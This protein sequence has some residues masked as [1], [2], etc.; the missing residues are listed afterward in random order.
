MS[1]LTL[2]AKPISP[3]NDVKSVDDLV[4]FVSLYLNDSNTRAR[5][6]LGIVI[7]QDSL[8][9]FFEKRKN[10]VTI[11]KYSDEPQIFHCRLK[12]LEPHSTAIS[13]APEWLMLE[14]KN[15]GVFLI[16]SLARYE[17]FNRY[18][19]RFLNRIY[20]KISR[21]YFNTEQIHGLVKQIEADILIQQIA[22]N[23]DSFKKEK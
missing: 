21:V 11:K 1:A 23:S 22:T 10:K 7:S 4:R 18:I 15:S 5:V 8:G 17:I 3:L 16:I 9:S 13:D 14:H 19:M 6:R 12:T 20:P 2:K